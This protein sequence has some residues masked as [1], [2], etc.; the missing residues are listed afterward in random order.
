MNPTGDKT[1]DT[2]A[3][4]REL[5]EFLRAIRERQSPEAHGLSK[6]AR[7][8]AT[9]LRREEVALLC[10]I[11]PTWYTWIEQGRTQAV[12]V[13]TLNSL[14]QGL[15]LS[16]AE[17]S[18]LFQLANRADP[19]APAIHDADVAEY[20]NLVDDILPPAYMLDRH[21]DVIA[22]NA[23]AARLFKGWLPSPKERERPFER[24]ILRFVFRNAKA[25]ELIV[26]W[27]E[28]VKR[29]AAEYRADS[30]SWHDD[31]L[32]QALVEELS[33]ASPEFRQTWNAQK[34]LSREGGV[35]NFHQKNRIVG[36]LQFTLR[37]AR[38]NDVKL[39]ILHPLEAR[40]SHGQPA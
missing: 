20:Q 33:E 29:L 14:S 1:E 8:R 12:S 7:R 4:N 16:Q 34:V 31:P 28:R 13:A 39:I 25:Q 27:P 37:M 36:F 6:G 32:H 24:N 18:Y 38:Q 2:P 10:G 21:W 26:D 30:A 19:M 3:H 17:R 23:A 11:S 5:G 9:G 22:W 35:R 40:K 15:K